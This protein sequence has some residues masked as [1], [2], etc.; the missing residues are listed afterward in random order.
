MPEQPF[1]VSGIQH[2]LL[3]KQIELQL[4]QGFVLKFTP[5]EASSL[6]F[7]LVA[8]RDGISP[9]RE[10]YM[11]PIASDAAFVGTVL[12]HG[13]SIAMPVGALELDWSKVGLLA[14]SL[15]AAIAY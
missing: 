1:S 11:S 14:E 12:D 8:V 10:I 4:A 6:S 3:G 15:A 5:A 2:R 9:E 7:A 13:M